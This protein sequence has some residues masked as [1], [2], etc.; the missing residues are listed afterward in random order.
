MTLDEI[1][2]LRGRQLFF[3]DEH[4]WLTQQIEAIKGGDLTRIDRKS[5]VEF[6]TDALARDRREFESH[7]MALLFLLLLLK[8]APENFTA[9]EASE[10]V[11]QQE[12]IR[13]FLRLTPSLEAEAAAF[14]ANAYGE[15]AYQVGSDLRLPPNAVPEQSPWTFEEALAFDPPV[16]S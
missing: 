2:Q 6:L 14:V 13:S 3:R 16:I 11:K 1:K 15:A 10:I 5:M 9:K 8:L 4:L 7:L 12:S